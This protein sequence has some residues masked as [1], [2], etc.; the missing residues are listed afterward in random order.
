MK[1]IKII[2]LSGIIAIV[3]TAVCY[4][5]YNLSRIIPCEY[6]PF[7]GFEDRYHFL[8]Q[9]TI[10][11]NLKKIH[12]CKNNN[13]EAIYAYKYKNEYRFFIWEFKDCNF[14]DINKIKY[15][16]NIDV[17]KEHF[18]SA[19]GTTLGKN[20]EFQEYNRSCYS[21]K[22]KIDVCFD[23]GCQFLN[24]IDSANY[25]CFYGNFNKL[26]VVDDRGEY[27]ILFSY[28]DGKYSYPAEII[29]YREKSSFFI[30]IINAINN[31]ELSENVF[32]LL[33]LSASQKATKGTSA[34]NF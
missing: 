33:K 20:P 15:H 9:D 8:F 22:S 12:S 6:K 1:K 23:S 30:L 16:K 28:D 18:V 17:K 21:I 2:A 19:S 24:E 4:T 27:Q 5:I 11:K 32:G 13:D 10:I 25:R 7:F 29:F 14:I 3:I 31:A 26:G 34:G